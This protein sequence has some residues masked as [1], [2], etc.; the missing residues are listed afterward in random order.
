ME[1]GAVEDHLHEAEADLDA[2]VTTGGAM[3][4]EVM[5][6]ATLLVAV[7]VGDTEADLEDTHH[8]ERTYLCN[9][10]VWDCLAG[11]SKS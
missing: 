1:V 10:C 3:T 2:E 8:I 9:G 11:T 7:T 6:V 4:G 5:I